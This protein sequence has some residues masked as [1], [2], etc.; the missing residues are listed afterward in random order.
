MII[1]SSCHKPIQFVVPLSEHAPTKPV[2][3][4]NQKK[5]ILIHV[6]TVRKAFFRTIVIGVRTNAIWAGFCG[7][8][9]ESPLASLS[10]TPPSVMSAA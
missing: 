1:P 3:N 5:V 7:G 10:H 8:H 2:L 6:K 4:N 9:N